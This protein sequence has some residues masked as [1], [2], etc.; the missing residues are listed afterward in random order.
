MQLIFKNPI[1]IGIIFGIITF[2]ILYWMVYQENQKRNPLD[3]QKSVNLLIPIIVSVI[4][5][6]LAGTFLDYMGN[7]DNKI[8]QTISQL[9]EPKTNYLSE[10]SEVYYLIGKNNIKLP[11]TDVFIDV[12]KF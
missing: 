3:K 12:A 2:L 4:V 7:N 5:W 9:P 10:G 8:E 6:F 1:I 11:S